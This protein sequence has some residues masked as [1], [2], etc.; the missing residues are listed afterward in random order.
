MLGCGRRWKRPR[1][2][3][4]VAGSR[5]GTPRLV[6]DASCGGPG[7]IPNFPWVTVNP[8]A[9]TMIVPV[10][11]NHPPNLDVATVSC[12]TWDLTNVVAP[13]TQAQFDPASG[14]LV[15]SFGPTGKVML[16]NGAAG[17]VFLRV[18]G[19]G[20]SSQVNSQPGIAVLASGVMCPSGGL[21]GPTQCLVGEGF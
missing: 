15:F 4:A 17:S 8:G 14:P 16:P 3:S 11:I 2:I 10:D 13:D 7:P 20:Q 18:R 12:M 19:A 21:G 1:S 5:I 9:G 6:V